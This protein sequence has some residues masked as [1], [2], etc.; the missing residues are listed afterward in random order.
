M[1]SNILADKA[2]HDPLE[3]ERTAPKV[4]VQLSTTP[5]QTHIT[6]NL[7]LNFEACAK[8]LEYNLNSKKSNQ[9]EKF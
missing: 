9:S 3:T 1:G 6:T 2:A 8:K 4:P 5:N 7:V